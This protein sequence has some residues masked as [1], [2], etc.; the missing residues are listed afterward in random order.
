MKTY[1]LGKLLSNDLVLDV[2]GMSNAMFYCSP[3]DS[4]LER[5]KLR[6]ETLEEVFSKALYS[7]SVNVFV[8]FSPFCAIMCVLAVQMSCQDSCGQRLENSFSMNAKKSKH[9][10]L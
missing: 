7:F 3:S 5:L 8:Y 2:V 10:S 6:A 4:K 1:V 9:C